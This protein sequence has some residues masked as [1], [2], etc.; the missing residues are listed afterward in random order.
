MKPKNSDQAR[1]WANKRWAN[2]YTG[3]D[4]YLEEAIAR[5]KA[6]RKGTHIAAGNTNAVPWLIRWSLAGRSDQV[7]LV[8]AGKVIKTCGPR[9]LPCAW[10]RKRVR[11]HAAPTSSS[12]S[13]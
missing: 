4:E 5:F 1:S 13:T 10:M 3:R 11:D 7:D 9:H 12:T 2:G 6:D 8:R